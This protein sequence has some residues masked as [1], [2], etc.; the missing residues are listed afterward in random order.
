MKTFYLWP[1]NGG[2]ITLLADELKQE[3]DELGHA[4]LVLSTKS[5]ESG[6]YRVSG[7]VGWSK[8]ADKDDF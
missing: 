2:S 5:K 6:R 3:N 1:T 8:A 4:W 7:L